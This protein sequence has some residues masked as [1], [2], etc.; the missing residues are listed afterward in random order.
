MADVVIALVDLIEAEGVVLRRAT[1]R[2][3]YGLALTLLAA[4]ALGVGAGLCLWAIYL[5]LLSALDPATARLLT[6]LLTL[7]IG[8]GLVWVARRL[9]R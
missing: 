5:Y 6:G 4:L 1:A 2:L 3:G 9:S 8:G 7:L